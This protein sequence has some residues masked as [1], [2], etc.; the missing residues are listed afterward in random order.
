MI[1]CCEVNINDLPI[2]N[3]CLGTGFQLN[4]IVC[5]CCKKTLD[6]T[7]YNYGPKYITCEKCDGTG[8]CL[9]IVPNTSK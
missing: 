8:K 9:F 6:N 7:K 4:E 5:N 1:N 3:K 2:C